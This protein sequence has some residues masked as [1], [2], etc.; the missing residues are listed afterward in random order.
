MSAEY[1]PD[2]TRRA[3]VRPPGRLMVVGAV[4]VALGA[5]LWVLSRV[6]AGGE[7][8]AFAPGHA[9]P[10]LVNLV[11]NHTYRLAV[12]GGVG[13]EQRLGVPPARP[14]CTASPD[15]GQA[16]ALRLT[17]ETSST[18]AVDTI[19][20]FQ[21]PFTGPAH[22]RCGGLPAVYVEGVG[23]DP[24]GWLLVLA[25]IALTI[26]VALLLSGLRS[27]TGSDVERV[28]PPAESALQFQRDSE[29]DVIGPRPRDDLGA[30]R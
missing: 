28:D 12:H 3:G 18:K 29:A 25:T 10:R 20:S 5:V 15:G 23:S 26:G 4:L 14:S 11:A 19:A 27:R 13:A 7:A 16:V 17:A 30:E 1:S 9:P 22:L 24:S 8:H 2:I 21:A 6:V